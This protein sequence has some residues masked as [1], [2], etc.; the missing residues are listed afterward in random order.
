MREKGERV[1]V[2]ADGRKG[3]GRI[4]I[5]TESV[6]T[7]LEDFVSVKTR[8]TYWLFPP[9]PFPNRYALPP[10]VLEL[11]P[12]TEIFCWHLFLRNYLVSNWHLS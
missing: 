8:E 9:S 5:Q 3:G 4:L 10:I 2:F 11:Q 1:R 6:D 12:E 7:F